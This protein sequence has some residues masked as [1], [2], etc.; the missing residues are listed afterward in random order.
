[1]RLLPLA[2]AAADSLQTRVLAA[3]PVNVVCHIDLQVRSFESVNFLDFARLLAAFSDR[4][5]YDDKVRF[6]FRVYDVDGDGEQQQRRQRLQ[7][8]Q[9]Q[10][11]A[12]HVTCRLLA[13][14]VAQRQTSECTTS[15][16]TVSSSSSSSERNNMRTVWTVAQCQTVENIRVVVTETV[17][18]YG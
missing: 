11:K 18:S 4:A 7:Q 3:A 2:L 6:I 15:T 12:L 8:R 1:L 14:V 10:L 17:N 9:Q 5:S 13:R 16:E